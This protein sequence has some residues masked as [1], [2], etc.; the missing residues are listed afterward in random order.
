MNFSLR[1]NLIIVLLI[2]LVSS[3]YK[4]QV[5]PVVVDF[6]YVVAEESYTVPVALTITNK[7]TGADFYNWTFEGAT[8]SSSD[9]KQPGEIQY[10]KAGTYKITLEAWNDTERSSKEIMVTLDSAVTLDFD[11]KISVNDF[12]P[13]TV[14]VTNHT[15][16]A[17]TYEWT[18]QGGV[19]ATSSEADPPE[20]IFG[21]AGDHTIS[22]RVTNGRESFSSSKV[23]TLKPLLSP[24]FDIVPNFEDEDYEAPLTAKLR[25]KTVSGLYY[26]WTSTGGV[27][28][29]NTAANTSITFNAPG[30]YHITLQAD[31][32]KEIKNIEHTIVVK[33]NT[34]LYMMK[35]IKLGVSAAQAT[36]G[37]FYSNTL[38]TVIKKDSLTTDNGGDIDIVFFAINAS[39]SYTRFVSPDS[40]A[41]FTFPAIPHAKHTYFINTLPAGGISFSATQFDD[42]TTD[43][44][45]AG[46]SIKANDTGTAF[47]NNT[48]VPYIVLFETDDGR[49]GA[50]KIK[51]FVSNGAQS[52]IIVDVKVQKLKS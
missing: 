47:F 36:I 46:L 35:D 8:P 10:S 33:P 5:I 23:I 37:S 43:V 29:N 13:A 42:M 19:P 12:A 26:S 16:G 51:S 6:S 17:S 11:V 45:L 18:F 32:D 15:R 30:E 14:E 38:R 27:I 2:T 52:Y 49:K 50:I 41:R 24:A 3:C 40:S 20:V 9:D 25:N 1:N 44:P 39:Y 34:N 21:S 31:N 22:L 7:T 4:E 48:S 28:A